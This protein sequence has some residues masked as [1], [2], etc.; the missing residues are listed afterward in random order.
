MSKSRFTVTASEFPLRDSARAFLSA[1]CDSVIRVSIPTGLHPFCNIRKFSKSR[2]YLKWGHG[3]SIVTC[4]VMLQIP[5]QSPIQVPIQRALQSPLQ[6]PLQG[7]SQSP[8]QSPLPSPL[9]SP[10]QTLSTLDS[11]PESIPEST[12][13]SIPES[14]PEFIS[15]SIPESIPLAV[16]VLCWGNFLWLSQHVAMPSLTFHNLSRVAGAALA[17]LR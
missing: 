7:P 12:P 2:T 6:G 9:P 1:I 5:P 8:L 3:L 11:N 14:T 17:D 15:E 16:R 4:Q 13:G 10:L